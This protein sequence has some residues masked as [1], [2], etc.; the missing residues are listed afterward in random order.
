[1]WSV[2]GVE[3]SVADVGK[4][5]VSTTE[6]DGTSCPR[7]QPRTVHTLEAST[8]GDERTLTLVSLGRGSF[9]TV[10]QRGESR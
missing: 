3:T 9:P 2:P 7:T 5:T 4:V 8:D 10:D 6:I 1:M